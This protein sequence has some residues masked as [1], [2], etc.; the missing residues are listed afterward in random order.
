MQNK[1]RVPSLFGLLAAASFALLIGCNDG[2]FSGAGNLT[3][4]ERDSGKKGNGDEANPDGKPSGGPNDIDTDTNNNGIPDSEEGPDGEDGKNVTDP[5]SSLDDGGSSN[6]ELYSDGTLVQTRDDRDPSV[7]IELMDAKDTSKVIKSFVASAKK[8]SS[9][10]LPKMCLK[11]RETVW[12]VTFGGDKN[13]V[14]GKKE[15]CTFLYSSGGTAAEF[16]VDSNGGDGLFGIG[17]CKAHEDDD[18]KVSCPS[19]TKT[20]RVDAT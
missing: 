17:E 9:V 18:Y 5:N 16:G 4:T 12:R 3:K 15:K 20:L 19:D 2:Q 11:G 7:T 8:K 10:V 6:L 14:L 1:I 13:R